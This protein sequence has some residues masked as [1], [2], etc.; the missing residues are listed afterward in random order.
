MHTFHP[1]VTPCAHGLRQ[2]LCGPESAAHTQ[3]AVLR[4]VDQGW[5]YPDAVT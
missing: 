2:S 1:A 3:T 5:R 4:C